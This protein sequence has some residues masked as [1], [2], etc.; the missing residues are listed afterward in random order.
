MQPNE[1]IEKI[2]IIESIIKHR[3][4]YYSN[5]NKI[6]EIRCHPVIFIGFCIK[7]EPNIKLYSDPLA[8]YVDYSADGSYIK[9]FSSGINDYSQLGRVKLVFEDRT[10]AVDY[11]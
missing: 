8:T 2:K 4:D 3:R 1:I 10:D 9:I 6:I 7:N 11:V 5:G